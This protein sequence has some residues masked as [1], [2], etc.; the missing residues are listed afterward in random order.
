V[1]QDSTYT[2]FEA[3]DAKGAKQL[4]DQVPTEFGENNA[5]QSRF[6]LLNSMVVGKLEGKEPYISELKK[7]V[8]KYPKSEEATRAKEILRLLGERVAGAALDKAAK[9]GGAKTNSNFTLTPDKSH[10]F[11]AALP[12][13]ASM[14]TC[15]AAVADYNG[16]YHRLEKL[17]IGNVYMLAEG[18]QTPVIVIR[19]FKTQEE[20]MSYYADVTGKMKEF[21]GGVEFTPLLISQG[22]YREVLRSKAF[23]EYQEFFSENYL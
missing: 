23:A 12:K 6:A 19:R 3:G 10:Y 13:G 8:S 2:T 7:V 4:I 18:E 15:K 21:M 16:E 14:S 17:V 9:T 1:P 22:N 5:L 11:L 20:G